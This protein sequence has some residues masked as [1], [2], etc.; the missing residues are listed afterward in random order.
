MEKA[1]GGSFT[2][3]T[4]KTDGDEEERR[5]DAEHYEILG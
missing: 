3:I 5:N 2:C 1:R 4:P